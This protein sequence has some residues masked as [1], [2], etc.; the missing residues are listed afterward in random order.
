MKTAKR[1]R[2]KRANTPESK[3]VAS[4]DVG[5]EPRADCRVSPFELELLQSLSWLPKVWA[6]PMDLGGRDA[7]KH[8]PALARLARRGLVL[9]RRRNTLMNMLGSHRGSYV[10]RISRRGRAT[11]HVATKAGGAK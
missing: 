2:S 5:R 3:A 1:P 8:S 4:V 7:S 6:R 10:Y 9:R 11:M